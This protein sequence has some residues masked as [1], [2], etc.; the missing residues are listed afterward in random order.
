MSSSYELQR[1]WDIGACQ[2]SYKT[3][4]KV[5]PTGQK[6]VSSTV[7]DVARM[8]GV[9]TATVSRVVN[10]APNV[11]GATRTKV[12]I[13]VSRLQFRPNEHAAQL[14]RANA[15][16]ARKRVVGVLKLARSDRDAAFRSEKQSA[17]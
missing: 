1:I 8:A 7:K 13:A 5:S 14:G 3:M 10:G 6:A 17:G 15:G 16:T 2:S 12:L 11:S 9:S 4:T